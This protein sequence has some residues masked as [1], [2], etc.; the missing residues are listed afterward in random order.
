MYSNVCR[1]LFEAHKLVYSFLISTS[2][3]KNAEILDPS[4][5]SVLLKGAD[6]VDH[7]AMPANP[8]PK[9]ISSI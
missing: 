4:L 8:D 6:M 1:G 9:R 3:N 2:I 5:F 7:S